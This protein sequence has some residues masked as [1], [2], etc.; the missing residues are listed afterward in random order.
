MEVNW[1]LIVFGVIQVLNVAGAT[2]GAM[3]W[4]VYIK[5]AHRVELNDMDAAHQIQLREI[6]GAYARDRI[7]MQE[8]IS[9]LQAQIKFLTTFFNARG[10]NIPQPPPSVVNVAGD[11]NNA[12]DTV[13]G[14]KGPR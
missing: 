5:R 3:A 10:F 11:Y 14:G 4:A 8:A 1:Y 6:D 9:D 13:A 12:G 7:N 2:A